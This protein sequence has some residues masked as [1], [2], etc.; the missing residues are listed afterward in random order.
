MGGV[1]RLPL[2][3]HFSEDR[4]HSL[5]A[6]WH[7]DQAVV[8]LSIWDGE[9]CIASFRLSQADLPRMATFLVTALG[10][11]AFPGAPALSTEGTAV[12]GD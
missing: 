2:R 10:D 7:P 5:Q 8:V 9:R 1:E 12:S 11:A 3:D 4:G 6:T